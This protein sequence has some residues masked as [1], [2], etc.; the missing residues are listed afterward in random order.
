MGEMEKKVRDLMDEIDRRGGA[1]KCVETGYFRDEI[2]RSAYDFQK[3]IES[4]QTV[5]VG[6]N[7]FVSQSLDIP[8]ILKVDPHLELN[9]VKELRELKA[10]RDPQ[11]VASLLAAVRAAAEN[12][13]NVVYPVIEAV[14]QYVTVGEIADVFREV[15]GEYNENI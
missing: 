11:Q 3:R 9:Q 1:V 12:G 14:E 7:E 8:S 13:D 4:K 15:W 10:S 5:L 2:A 6:V